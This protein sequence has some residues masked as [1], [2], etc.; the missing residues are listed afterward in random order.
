MF[1]NRHEFRELRDAGE[2]IATNILTDRL[3]SLAA[4]GIIDHI[5]HPTNRTKKIYFL[6]DRGK[7][8]LPLMREMILWGDE[9]CDGSMVPPER[10]EPVREH[11]IE[12]MAGVMATLTEW[13]KEYLVTPVK[14]V[15]LRRH[16]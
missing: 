6:T 16:T 14:S 10:I 3:R 1:F 12:F 13:E 15:E 5:P 4:A 9:H 8:L 7:S 2:G 11:G